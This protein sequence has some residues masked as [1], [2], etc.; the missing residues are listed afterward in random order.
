MTTRKPPTMSFPDWIEH[1]IR[2][3]EA[4]GAFDNLPGAGKPIPDIDRPQDELAWVANYLRRES[5]NVAEVLPPALALAKEVE[6]LP[7]R[8][9]KERTEAGA[10]AVVAELNERIS[11]AHA[12][13][14]VGPPLRVKLVNIEAAMDRW[15]QDL[16]ARAAATPVT[17]P[18]PVV[19]ARRRSWFGRRKAS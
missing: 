13:P 15:R 16:A 18:A 17:P 14:Q 2:A 8:L 11:R 3:A 12:R 5:G 19:P 1:Q 4:E 9:R 10:R 6:L 7:E